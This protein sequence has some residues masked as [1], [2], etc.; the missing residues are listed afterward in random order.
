MWLA[1]LAGILAAPQG[2]EDH[3]IPSRNVQPTILNLTRDLEASGTAWQPARTPVYGM[4]TKID[5]WHLMT[6]AALFAIYDTQTG[7]RGEDAV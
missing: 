2:H 5:D 7:E 6:H 1:L 4:H 3:E